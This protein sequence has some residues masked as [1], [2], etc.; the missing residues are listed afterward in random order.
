MCTRPQSNPW[1]RDFSPWSF[2][3]PC[4]NTIVLSAVR[5][6]RSQGARVSDKQRPTIRA[7]RRI[8]FHSVLIAVTQLATSATFRI[9]QTVRERRGPLSPFVSF[10]WAQ[11]RR[12]SVI[13][14]GLARVSWEVSQ[15]PWLI[16]FEKHIKRPICFSLLI[17]VAA[18]IVIYFLSSRSLL[19]LDIILN[20]FWVSYFCEFYTNVRLNVSLTL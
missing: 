4:G 13:A 12:N 10:V 20:L 7:I 6:K 18:L 19:T 15:V 11:L 17:I 1:Y 5:R 9:G 8:S 3:I 2:I 16:Y 14:S